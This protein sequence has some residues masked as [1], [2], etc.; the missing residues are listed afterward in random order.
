MNMAR[1]A[2]IAVVLIGMAMCT[3][4]IGKVAAYNAWLHPLSLASI[5][6]GVLALVIPGA[7]L[8]N[9]KLPLVENEIAGILAVVAIVVVK[10][11][12]TQIHGL[13]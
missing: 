9:V 12:L 2:L 6:L 11:V 1:I 10:F 8:L 3:G 4:G 7:V 5:A 13:A